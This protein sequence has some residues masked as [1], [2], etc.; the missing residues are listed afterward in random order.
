MVEADRYPTDEIVAMFNSATALHKESA[1]I[2]P[3]LS[4]IS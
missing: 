1:L 4:L 3:F 2:S